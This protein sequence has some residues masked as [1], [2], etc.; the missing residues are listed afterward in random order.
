VEVDELW[1]DADPTRL[2]QIVDNLLHNAIKYTPNGGAIAVRA[3]AAG[4][5]AV[6]EVSDTG[7]GIDAD[8]LP[9][10]FDA[11]VQGPTGIDRAQ[12]GLGL[13]LALVRELAALHGGS[14]GAHSAGPGKGSTFVLRLPL[15]QP[16][17][18]LV[19]RA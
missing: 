7:V 14:V 18:A 5:E 4:P 11:L 9:M 17:P 10:I 12:G 15:A 13:G 19:P 6:I 2:E 16:E 1:I 8:T 3:R